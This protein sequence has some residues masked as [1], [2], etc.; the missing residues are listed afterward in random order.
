MTKQKDEKPR[1]RPKKK[2]AQRRSVY[3]ENRTWERLRTLAYFEGKSISR[4]IEEAVESYLP[5]HNNEVELLL[6]WNLISK[7]TAD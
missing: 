3:I 7:K 1:G 4:L 6:Q 2:T 5:A